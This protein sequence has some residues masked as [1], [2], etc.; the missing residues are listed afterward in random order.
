MGK[1]S[2]SKRRQLEGWGSGRGSGSGRGR[3]RE[4]EEDRIGVEESVV[5]GREAKEK[6]R[7]V[8]GLR[9][10]GMVTFGMD[11]PGRGEFANESQY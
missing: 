7:G 10:C 2:E 3:E 4:R 11:V 6:K 8:L 9:R 5:C 1:E